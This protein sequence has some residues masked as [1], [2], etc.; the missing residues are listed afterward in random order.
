VTT[1]GGVPVEPGMR[2]A[3]AE[4]DYLFGSGGVVIVVRE[5][6]GVVDH[7]DECWVELH[8]DQLIAGRPPAVPRLLTVR[9]RA[10]REAPAQKA[11]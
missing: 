5:V 8:A 4:K 2:F 10:L 9:L 11:G 6:M 7:H 1:I 3:L